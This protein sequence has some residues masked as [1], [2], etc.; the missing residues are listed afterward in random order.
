MSDK[1]PLIILTG[2]TAVGKTELS[3]ML[4]KEMNAEIISADSI[5]VYKYMDI[6]SAKITKEEM[7]GIKHYLVDELNPSEDFS[8]F[9]FKEMTLKYMDEIYSKGRIPI[10]AGGTG[11]YIQ[12]VLYNIN[13][14]ETDDE[15]IYRKELEA[16]A[17][18]KGPEYLHNKLK[19]IDAVTAQK[20][21]SNNVKRVIRALEYYNDTGKLLSEHNEEQQKNDS[22]YNFKYFVLNDD[23]QLL[24][25]RINKRVDKMFELGLVKEVKNLLNMG[26]G[27]NL[28]SMQG[29]GYKETVAY[30]L[31]EMNLEDT[32]ELIKKNTRHFAKRQL[33]WFRKEKEVTWIDYREYGNDKKVM[34]TKMTEMCRNAGICTDMKG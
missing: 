33:T 23:R 21:H 13:F 26:Y 4:A 11:F 14:S 10:I 27:R 19:E 32:I 34:S 12:S 3:V 7:Q 16:I 1:K 2:P 24:Y 25:D 5:Q 8:I 18:E 29:I 30:I 9:K 28:V 6:G 20:V 17:K 31:G 22:P 15:H